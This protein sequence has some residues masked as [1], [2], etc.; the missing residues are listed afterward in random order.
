VFY[1]LIEYIYEGQCYP[2]IKIK[3][4]P[5]DTLEVPLMV[6][7]GVP[8][9]LPE[10]F[11]WFVKSSIACG[12][13]LTTDETL[14]IVT[15]I[16]KL[17]CLAQRYEITDMSSCCLYKLRLCPFETREVTAL[18]ELVSTQIPE[19]ES[20]SKIYAFMYENIRIQKP[21]LDDCLAF[22]RLFANGIVPSQTLLQILKTTKTKQVEYMRKLSVKNLGI[23][24]CHE[25][26]TAADS[27]SKYGPDDDQPYKFGSAKI[28]EV[29][30]AR[31]GVIPEG[32]FL[33]I[34]YPAEQGVV[35]HRS[36]FF[37]LKANNI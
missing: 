19:T 10:S 27:L 28:G 16:I 4:E 25:D 5:P 36:S 29:F 13:H 2:Q 37:F 30:S 1:R 34:N 9:A 14:S 17:L 35:F 7:R 11:E 22:E 21:R 6:V 18:V 31:G 20:T 15:D 12:S 26:V 32:L 8:G 24:V 23:A 33:A 3:E